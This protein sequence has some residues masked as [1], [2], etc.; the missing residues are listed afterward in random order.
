MAIDEKFVNYFPAANFHL[1]NMMNF[2]FFNESEASELEDFC[3]AGNEELNI[4]ADPPF[5]AMVNVIMRTC[6]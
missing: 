5:G 4:I 3:S 6:Q 2:H 1:F